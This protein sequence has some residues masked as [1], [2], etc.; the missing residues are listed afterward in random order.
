MVGPSMSPVPLFVAHHPPSFGAGCAVCSLCIYLLDLF[1][2]GDGG[3]VS[4][5]LGIKGAPNQQLLDFKI[6]FESSI[7]SRVPIFIR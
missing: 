7:I 4:I 6:Q 3:D 5:T 2:E 1:R